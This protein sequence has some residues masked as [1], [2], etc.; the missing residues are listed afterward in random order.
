M[1]GIVIGTPKKS[2]GISSKKSFVAKLISDESL[3]LQQDFEV[4][5][6]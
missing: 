2:T 1:C 5:L 4:P 3:A 6:S